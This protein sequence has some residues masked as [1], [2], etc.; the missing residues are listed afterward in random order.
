MEYPADERP[1]VIQHHPNIVNSSILKSLRLEEDCEKG[2][3]LE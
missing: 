3:I 1:H 2:P